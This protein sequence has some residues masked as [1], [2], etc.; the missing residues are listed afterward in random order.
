MAARC[1][2]LFLLIALGTSQDAEDLYAVLDIDE[3]A[4]AGE[5]KKAYRK[6]SLRH[7]PDKGGDSVVFKEVSRAYEVLGD[8]EKRAL[9]DAGGMEA[10]EKGVGATDM[11][12]RP[13]GPQRGGDVSVTAS[14]SLEDMYRGGSVRARVRR[15]VVCRGCGAR[16]R[17][18][19]NCTGCTASCPP[20]L[21]TVQRRVGMMLMQQQVETPSAERCREDT[22][23]LHAAIER[24]AADGAQVVFPRASEQTPGRIPGDVIV[25]LK[26]SRHAVFARD[27]ADLRMNMSVPL[28]AALL[29]F[30][31]TIRHLDGHAV[32]ISRSVI[33]ETGDVITLAGQGMPKLGTPSEHGLLHVVLHV[34]MPSALTAAERDFVS[35]NFEPPDEQGSPAG[36]GAAPR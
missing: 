31:R 6:Q 12:G 18:S 26:A 21:K 14:V 15:R 13:T 3:T 23:T 7:H 10:V 17:P 8:G 9:Y 24:G 35:T 19:A 20:E 2:V 11:F 27:G 30:E 22:T 28:R 1:Y 5:V 32:H 25:R 16:R 34:S 29:G 33:S 4:T 36:A